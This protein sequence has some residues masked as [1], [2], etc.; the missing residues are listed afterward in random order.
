MN[1]N[2]VRAVWPAAI[3]FFALHLLHGQDITGNWQ[4]TLNTD[5]EKLRVILQVE[6]GEGAS[7]KGTLYSIDQTPDGMPVTAFSLSDGTTKFSVDPFHISYEGKLASDGNTIAGI[8]TQGKPTPLTFERATK[9]TAWQIDSS[10]HK[11]Q[12]TTVEGNIKLEVLDWGGT[13]RPL[14]LLTGLGNAA[15]VYDKFALKL[16]PNYHVYGITRRGFGASSAPTPTPTNY[17]ADRLG[18]DVLA[19]I[20]A[21]HLDRPILVGHSIAGEELSSIGTRHPEKVAALIYLD[22]GYPHALYDKVHGAL[23]IDAIEVREQINQLFAGKPPADE[24]QLI[25]DLLVNLQLLQKGLQQQQQDMQAVPPPPPPAHPS[26]PPPAVV[27]IRE[28]VQRYDTIKGVPILAIFAVPHDL[29]GFMKDKPQLRAAMEAIDERTT[30][31]QASAFETQ[32]PNAKVIRIPH[33]NH[34]L[35]RSNEEDVLREMNA[36]IATLPKAQE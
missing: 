3:L 32:V 14:V 15:H 36:F 34:Y 13:G 24:K 35:F 31:N 20:D 8:V 5:K 17:K 7:L 29:G 16:T 11:V 21:L 9:A 28:G 23:L 12:L 6:K 25:D 22:A 19:V 27:A 26:A 18:D 4:G 10:P 33:A 2:N 1:R 30:S